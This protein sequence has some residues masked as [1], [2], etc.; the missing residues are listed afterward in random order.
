MP[1]A[2]TPGREGAPCVLSAAGPA[3]VL[4]R[5]AGGRAGGEELRGRGCGNGELEGSQK[6]RED[7]SVPSWERSFRW[8]SGF[9]L[10]WG[11]LS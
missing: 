6:E 11:W 5:A 4:G 3:A 7:S 10:C 2:F 8:G 1:P 9:G